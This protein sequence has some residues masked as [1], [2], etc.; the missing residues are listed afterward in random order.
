MRVQHYRDTEL[1]FQRANDFLMRAEAENN[2]FLGMGRRRVLNEQCYLATVERATEV[3]A[4]AVRTPPFGLVITRAAEDALNA[5][6][7]DLARIGAE[8]PSVLGPEPSA[9]AFAEG[10]SARFGTRTRHVTRMRMFEA[11]RVQPPANPPAGMLRPAHESDLPVLTEWMAA[12]QR[13]A[14]IET[15]L[16]PVQVTREAIAAQRL[17]VWDSDGPASIASYACRT[18]RSAR[19]G[20]AY[21]P[22]EIRRRGYASACVAALTQRLLGEG[23]CSVASMRISRTRPR[24]RSI[25][26]SGIALSA[27]PATSIWTRVRRG[28]KRRTLQSDAPA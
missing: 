5:L 6:T 1:F 11:R 26:L 8:V 17:F 7:D 19:I 23:C 25:R 18:D 24:T 20:M 9:S 15:P 28:W 4:C 13:D 10:W 12:F 16:D 21:T 3:V 22:P 27:I 14:K 2:M